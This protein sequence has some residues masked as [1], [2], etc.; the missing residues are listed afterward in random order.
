MGR[1]VGEV[2]QP[3][4]GVALSRLDPGGTTAIPGRPDIVRGYRAERIFRAAMYCVKAID[5]AM[6]VAAMWKQLETCLP[7]HSTAPRLPTFR[8]GTICQLEAQSTGRDGPHA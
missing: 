1:P 5:V 2:S 7:R 6:G 8:T 4:S 3:L